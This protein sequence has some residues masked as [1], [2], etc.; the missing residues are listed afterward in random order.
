MSEE[1]DLFDFKPIGLAIK[2]ARE[3]KGLYPPNNPAY[4]KIK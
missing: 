2:K 3:A 1:K 4:S